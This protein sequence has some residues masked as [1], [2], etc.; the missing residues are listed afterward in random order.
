[1]LPNNVVLKPATPTVLVDEYDS[2]HSTIQFNQALKCFG[3]SVSDLEMLYI[4]N[5]EVVDKAIDLYLYGKEGGSQ[6]AA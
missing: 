1:M 3:F 2:F 4:Y 5:P 6:D